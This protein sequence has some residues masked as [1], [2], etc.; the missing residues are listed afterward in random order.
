MSIYGTVTYAVTY[1][2]LLAIY[3]VYFSGKTKPQH[4][5]TLMELTKFGILFEVR[6]LKIGDFAWIARCR[7]T[8][9]ELIIPYIIERK[10]MDD[11]SGSIIDG[12]F[13]EQKVF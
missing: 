5:A 12:R 7:K 4:D 8:K 13:H 9:D 10:R 11:L 6:R 3:E 2:K 1:K